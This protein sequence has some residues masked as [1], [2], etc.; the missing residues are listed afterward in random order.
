MEGTDLQRLLFGNIV[1]AMDTELFGKDVIRSKSSQKKLR[2]LEKLNMLSLEG[3]TTDNQEKEL[4]LL[5]AAMPTSINAGIKKGGA[6]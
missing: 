5:R 4:Q 2:R 1:E 3:E 6:R